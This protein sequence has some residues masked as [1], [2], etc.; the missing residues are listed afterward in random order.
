MS[1]GV[2]SLQKDRTDSPFSLRDAERLPP[3]AEPLSHRSSVTRDRVSRCNINFDLS[4]I[5]CSNLRAD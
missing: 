4:V 3:S 5:A 1:A 2:K